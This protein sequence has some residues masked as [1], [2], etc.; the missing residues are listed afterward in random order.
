MKD[1]ATLFMSAPELDNPENKIYMDYAK[2]KSQALRNGPGMRLTEVP[3]SRLEH[4]PDEVYPEG[5]IRV[6]DKI[7]SIHSGDSDHDKLLVEE[8]LQARD[9]F[10]LN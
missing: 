7:I 8:I 2:R 9:Q 5:V 1:G 3:E 10:L 6:Y 4:L